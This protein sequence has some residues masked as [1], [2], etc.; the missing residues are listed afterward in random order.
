MHVL[1]LWLAA[2]PTPSGPA[3]PATYG[4]GSTPPVCADV[5]TGPF[6][7]QQNRRLR[8]HFI[9]ALTPGINRQSPGTGGPDSNRTPNIPLGRALGWRT[10]GS[11]E[12]IL[13]LLP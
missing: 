9:S 11:R 7:R 13:R 10:P 2:N 12:L 1:T 5:Q 8:C 3:L 4:R 6:E